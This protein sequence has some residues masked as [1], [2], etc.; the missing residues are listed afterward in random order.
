AGVLRPAD[1]FGRLGG[2][3]F[4]VLLPGCG[5][6]GAL[7][8]VERLKTAVARTQTPVG[9][10]TVSV[11]AAALRP[12]QDLARLLADA[13]LGLMEAKRQGRIRVCVS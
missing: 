10:L 6:T 12:G 13:D 1:L 3:E 11:G 4:A 7:A 9:P 5:L 8:V 2:D